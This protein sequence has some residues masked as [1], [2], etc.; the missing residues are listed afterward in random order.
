MSIADPY[1][2]SGQLDGKCLCGSVG[3]HIDGDY[4]AAIGVC[5]CSNCQRSNGTAWGAFQASPD[6]VRITGN[7]ARY[8]SAPFAE[9]VFCPVCGSNL[10]LRDTDAKDAPYEFMPALFPEAADFPLISEVYSDR[11]PAYASFAGDHRRVTRA[12][13]EAKNPHVEGDMP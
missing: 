3:L 11:A 12:E 8:A 13:Y 1:R 6:A 4:V 10:W 2:R 5:H 7:V 9:R